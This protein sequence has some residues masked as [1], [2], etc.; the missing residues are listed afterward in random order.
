MSSSAGMAGWPQQV[1]AYFRHLAGWIDAVDITNA[2]PGTEFSIEANSHKAFVYWRNDRE[3]YFIEARRRVAPYN[4]LFP[5]GGLAIWHIHKDGREGHDFPRIALVQADG[6]KDI[7]NNFNRGDAA[8]LFRP[9]VSVTFNSKTNPAAVWH[10]GTP[11]GLSLT[12]ISDTGAV[13]TFKIGTGK[14][15]DRY[16][17]TGKGTNDS[18]YLIGTADNLMR[19]AILVNTRSAAI[20][21]SYQLTADIDLS[22]YGKGRTEWNDGK[23]WVPIGQIGDA[24]I[25]LFRGTFDG[26]NKKITGLYINDPTLGAA[27]LFGAIT[28]G[29]VVKN[30]GIV[31]GTVNGVKMGDGKIYSATEMVGGSD[32]TGGVVGW[33][34]RGAS[35]SNCYFTGTV[36]GY[37]A[38]GGV[39]GDVSGSM[40]DSYSNATITGNRWVGG[41]AGNVTGSMANVYSTGTVSGEQEVGGVAGWVNEDGSVT[42]SAA[43]NSSVTRSAGSNKFIGRVAGHSRGKL[44]GN[45]ACSGMTGGPFPS[46]SGGNHVNGASVLKSKD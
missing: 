15:V 12:E 8:D 10:D 39:A 35:V 42:N 26:N 40:T 29:G 32:M 19:M 38:V 45:T 30:L 41:V 16:A 36:S 9:P 14:E 44:S 43:L 1:N 3:G 27:G 33:V 46:G 23:G 11:S 5:T 31:D 34:G 28:D 18:P 4:H 22:E 7:E 25:R 37:R 20:K 2:A 17:F 24:G 6:K 21:D 13:M